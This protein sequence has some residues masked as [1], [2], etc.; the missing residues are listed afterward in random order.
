MAIERQE[1][2]GIYRKTVAFLDLPEP[3]N[4]AEEELLSWRNTFRY[5][6]HLRGATSSRMELIIINQQ[7]IVIFPQVS[8]IR[9]IFI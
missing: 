2:A 7:G 8:I 6:K 9:I 1:M 5:G 3:K 4:L